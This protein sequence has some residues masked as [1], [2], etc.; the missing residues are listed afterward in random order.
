MQRI[1]IAE[2]NLEANKLTAVSRETQKL[3]TFQELVLDLE[4]SAAYLRGQELMLTAREFSIVEL[5]MKYPDKVFS[6]EDMFERI[7]G[8]EYLCEDNTLK[9]HISNIRKKIK[10][11][12]PDGEYID[13][14]WGTGYCIHKTKG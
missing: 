6:K 13:T 12:C 14:V 1:P 8:L 5:L 9:V 2:D 10:E 4:K 7:W 11:I 3:L